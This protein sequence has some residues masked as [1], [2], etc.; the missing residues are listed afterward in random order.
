MLNDFRLLQ[1]S[2]IVQCPIL[3]IVVPPVY[4]FFF[5]FS[6]RV[7]NPPGPGPVQSPTRSQDGMPYFSA[8]FY[9][10][11]THT[12][13]HTQR[14][15]VYPTACRK[16]LLVLSLCAKGR[17]NVGRWREKFSQRETFA[18]ETLMIRELR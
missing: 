17:E 5:F 8:S 14:E 4:S 18:V 12:H 2:P 1:H 6:S 16:D 11:R 7:H 9:S 3:F 15:R 10:L 13:T